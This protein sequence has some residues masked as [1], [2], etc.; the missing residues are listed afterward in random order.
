M[1]VILFHSIYS[2]YHGNLYRLA[3]SIKGRETKTTRTDQGLIKGE[4][5]IS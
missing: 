2:G 4:H 1:S 3:A 5:G